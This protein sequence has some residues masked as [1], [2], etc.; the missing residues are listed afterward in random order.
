MWAS[1]LYCLLRWTITARITR[2]V[3]AWWLGSECAR[4][5]A[6]LQTFRCHNF[7]VFLVIN[8]LSTLQPKE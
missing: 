8:I 4:F 5:S 3:L 6:L 1:T 2:W 7:C